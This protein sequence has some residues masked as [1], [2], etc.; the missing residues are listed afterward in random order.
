M[1]QLALVPLFLSALTASAIGP[2]DCGNGLFIDALPFVDSG[3]TSVG[4]DIVALT[5]GG[6]ESDANGVVYTYTPPLD[7]LIDVSLCGSA[8]DTALF[9]YRYGS[10]APIDCNDDACE[11][12]SLQSEIIGLP[13]LA[14]DTYCILVTGYQAQQGAYTLVVAPSSVDP[15]LEPGLGAPDVGAYREASDSPFYG[16]IGF[17]LE[18]FEDGLLDLRGVTETTGNGRVIAPS[19]L[20]DSVDGDDGSIDGSGNGGHSYDDA[21]SNLLSFSFDAGVIGRYPTQAGLVWTDGGNGNVTVTFEAFD[22]NGNSL[23][24]IVDTFFDGDFQGQTDDDRFYGVEY[25]RGISRIDIHYSPGTFFEIDHLQYA[26]GG[27]NVLGDYNG[28]GHWDCL[29]VDAMSLVLIAST[30]DAL[31]DLDGDGSVN[32]IDFDVW[33]ELAGAQHPKDTGG[34][35]FLHGD[36]NL[37][38]VVDGYDFLIWNQNKF[39]TQTSWCGG[40]FNFDG[41]VLGADFDIW[42][43][44]RFQASQ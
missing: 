9:V 21:G 33:L 38:G 36:A 39:T 32:A 27:P 5:C 3:D 18:D 34:N 12:G 6:I 2:D 10:G 23:G 17:A 26:F 1:R 16:S 37:D 35:P 29:D 4:V 24:D 20:T 25:A 7:R 42:F 43:A 44:A 22:A 41:E 28:D 14:G 19:G 8:Y 15:F 40:D 30:Y 13:V 31:M 11:S